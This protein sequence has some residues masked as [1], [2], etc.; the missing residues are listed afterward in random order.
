MGLIPVN[1]REK[2]HH[3]LVLAEEYL[4]DDHVIGIFPEGT[5]NHTKETVMPFK[6]GFC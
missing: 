5:F 6:I 3:S 4:K 2:S 1:R